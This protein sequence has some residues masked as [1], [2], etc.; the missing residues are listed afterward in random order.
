MSEERKNLQ[1]TAIGLLRPSDIGGEVCEGCE[2]NTRSRSR[3]LLHGCDDAIR[4]CASLLFEDCELVPIGTKARIKELETE[5]KLAW[6]SEAKMAAECA[7]LRTL[8]KKLLRKMHS[9]LTPFDI[10]LWIKNFVEESDE[11]DARQSEAKK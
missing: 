3:A 6:Q 1:L 4:D 9:G 5:N 11:C 2:H 8:L 7:R 10:E